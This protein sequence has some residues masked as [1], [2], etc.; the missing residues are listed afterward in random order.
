MFATALPWAGLRMGTASNAAEAP[1][2]IVEVG[3]V[4]VLAPEGH[5][6]VGWTVINP[7]TRR[8]YQLFEAVGS[9]HTTTIQSFDLDTLAPKRRAEVTGLL[10]IPVGGGNGIPPSPNGNSGD[11]VH[12]VD[13]AG[14]L[15]LPMTTDPIVYNTGLPGSDSTRPFEALVTIDERRF[16]AGSPDFFSTRPLPATQP[17]L[18]RHGVMGML[19]HK[20]S[21][22]GR[23]LSVWASPVYG[24]AHDHWLV[25]WDVESATPAPTSEWAEPLRPC[26]NA[27]LTSGEDG[28]TQ[29]GLLRLPRAVLLACQQA[30]LMGNNPLQVVRIE[31]D[32]T[33]RPDPTKD[34]RTFSFGRKINKVLADQ[35]HRRLLVSTQYSGETLLVFDADVNAW[36]GAIGIKTDDGIT[37]AGVDQTSGRIYVLRPHDRQLTPE[38]YLP[39]QGGLLYSDTALTPSP[40]LTN[41]RPDLAYPGFHRIL[42]DPAGPGRPTRIF[43]RRGVANVQSQRSMS[44]GLELTPVEPFYRVFVDRVPLPAASSVADLDRL[45]ADV[46]EAPGLTEAVFDGAATGYGVRSLTVGGIGGVTNPQGVGTSGACAEPDREVVAGEVR[47]T[48]LSNLLASASAAGLEADSTTKDDYRDPVGRCW[49]DPKISWEAVPP[50]VQRVVRNPPDHEGKASTPWP[51]NALACAGSERTPDRSRS[52]GT[53]SMHSSATCAHDEGMAGARGRLE[54]PR[55]SAPES[56]DFASADTRTE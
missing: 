20:G 21:G 52:V 7:A 48:K 3:R 4:P 36:S 32:A 2:G 40:Q 27:Q 29:D 43:V 22:S 55:S 39:V 50:D 37:T 33:G 30:G 9:R 19:F 38:G 24:G 12:A 13:P 25:E 56:V 45:T 1:A 16:D 5:E 41:I 44:G 15:F 17:Q 10:P 14:R 47:A 23:L 18:A 46:E 42:V 51:D 8:L 35:V 34:V 54:T 28:T 49:P 26:A 6:K 31:L 11:V 53:V